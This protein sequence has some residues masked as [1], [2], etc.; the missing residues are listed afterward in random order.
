MEHLALEVFDLKTK[1]NPNPTG[2]KYAV[3]SEDES[4]TITD[5][6]EIFASGD[7]W[8]YPFKLNVFAN[9]HIFGTAGDIHGGRLHEQID[10]RRVRLWVEGLPLYLGYLKLGDEAEVDENGDVDVTFESGRKTFDE[11]IEGGKAN[12]VPMMNDI[13][14]GLALWRKRWVN[15]GVELRASA[16]FSNGKTSYSDI[17]R[18]TVHL[19]EIGDYDPYIIPFF[20]DGE[21]DGKSVPLYPSMMFP[22]GEFENWSTGDENYSIDCLNTDT[23]YDDAHPF[24]NIALCYQKYGYEKGEGAPPDYSSEPEAQRGY[25]Y[26]P[27]SRVNSAPN[28]FVIYW[29]KC[30]MK[31]L[32]INI[33]E[34][35][36]MDVE[37]LRRLFFVNTKCSYREP[38]CL[39]SPE[40]DWKFGKYKF[41]EGKRYIA[42]QLS[43]DSVRGYYNKYTV[44]APASLYNKEDCGFE[45]TGFTSDPIVIDD[46]GTSVSIKKLHVSIE[47][48]VGMEEFVK[49][50]YEENNSFLH[51]AYAS[52]D[53]FPN[54]DIS[55]VVNALESGFGVRFLFSDNYQRVRIVLLRNIFRST[56]I[57]EITCDIMDGDVKVENSIRGFRMTYEKPEDT[58]FSYKGFSDMLPHKKELWESDSDTH[59]YSKWSLNASYS[60]I[61]NK[62]SA[63]DNT[64]YVTPNTGN[65]YGI[66]VDKNAK[67]ISEMHPSVFE[68][69]GYMDAE[70]GDCAG[71]DETINTINVG[72][73]PAIMNDLNME[74][75]RK[76]DTSEQR[77]ALFVD[78]EMRPRRADLQDG[79]DYNEPD[80]VYNVDTL[81]G[82]GSPASQMKSGGII[83]PGEFATASD[84]EVARDDLETT[85]RF[86]F[87]EYATGSNYTA[88]AGVKFNIKGH[89]NEGYRLYLQNNYEPNDDGVSPIEKKDWGLTLGI[90][91]GS[92]SDAYVNYSADPDDGED[93]DTWNIVPGSNA[94]AHPDTCDSYGNTWDYDGRTG[95]KAVCVTPA[96]AKEAMSSLWGDSHFDLTN[97]SASSYLTGYV[98]PEVTDNT[99][100]TH[101]IL[102]AGATSDQGVLMQR[103]FRVDFIHYL[104]GKSIE[105]MLEIDEE[106]G[107]YIIEIDSSQEKAQTLL[108]LQK[109]AY[110]N[111]GPVTISGGTDVREGRFSLKLRA[112]KPNPYFDASQPESNSNRRYL[113]ITNQNLQG[114]GLCDQFYKEYSY[115][116]RNARIIKRTVRM[117]LAQLLAIDKTKKVTIGD[118]TGFIKKTQYGV[119]NKTG[120]G[121]VTM[122]IMYI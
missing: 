36:M 40:Y 77:F 23:P 42:E 2:S 81:Y 49:S 121:M 30:L 101:K 98:L 21:E 24:C 111:G 108:A 91:R 9:A 65:A 33:E 119:S 14:I 25:E 60:N 39:R 48:I 75:E 96:D 22:K 58:S 73:T 104:Q 11:M 109:L 38:K 56:D 34:N 85:L 43:K 79:Q 87:Y 12:Q 110:A 100:K 45:V 7:V 120:L 17:V 107:G 1:D 70:D 3:L 88:T 95:Y 112:E 115:W 114:R 71:E 89:I 8:S 122:E 68:F 102:L 78:E 83:K 51:E 94:T 46:R 18:H 64:C 61:I 72:F 37:D 59:D 82:K 118:I 69:A 47:K 6:S 66:K 5:T 27:A 50:K 35:Q 74:E 26:M 52:S 117:E 31:Q 10:K 86:D 99:G 55:E 103:D 93:N 92:G 62:V 13:L 57:Q 106:I 19:I 67:K 28:F 63:F 113:E 84:M 116:I 76:G 90:M 4:I 16:Q 54:V 32:G 97:R 53:C 15:I 29:I 20:T 105:S 44:Y 41:K 80:A